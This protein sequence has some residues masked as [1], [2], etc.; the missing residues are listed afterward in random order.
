MMGI[1]GLSSFLGYLSYQS[2]MYM[3]RNRTR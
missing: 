3:F 2:K 1:L